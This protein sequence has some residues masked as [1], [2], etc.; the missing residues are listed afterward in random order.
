MKTYQMRALLVLCGGALL[1]SGCAKHEMVK[2]EETPIPPAVALTKPTS[3]QPAGKDTGI[4]STPIKETQ[5]MPQTGQ[6]PAALSKIEQLQ[7][8]LGIIY[9]DYDAATLSQQARTTLEKNGELLRSNPAVKIQIE[10]HCDE[11]GSDAYNLALGERRAKASLQY[12]ATLGIPDKRL[13]VISY[14]KEKPADLGHDE[15]SLSKN[16]RD[17]FVIV[18]Q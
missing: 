17:E 1:F 12:L 8:A 2:K 14:G 15:S 4:N 9:F 16:R 13:S 3:E 5:I 6:S 18:T 11:R 7:R 10:G